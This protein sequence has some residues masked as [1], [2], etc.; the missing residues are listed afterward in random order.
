VADEPVYRVD[1]S[2]RSADE[3]RALGAALGRAA[4]PGDVFLLDGEFGSGKT[5]LVQGLA[6]GLDVESF[7]ASPS[8]IIVNQH[9]GRLRLYHVDLFRLER[10]D[11]ELEDTLAE[12][13]DA[14]GV[15]AVE[16]S[17]LLPADLRQGATLLRFSRQDG[18]TRQIEL[19]TPS[20]RLATAAKTVARSGA[21]VMS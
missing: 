1:I 18:D 16:W 11:P 14:G 12:L 15:T 9:Q 3:T 10:L 7:V 8:F 17:R 20:E 2:S 13:L 19:E 4:E 6:A 5:V 21:R